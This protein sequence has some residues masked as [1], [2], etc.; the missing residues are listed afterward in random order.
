ME[1][2]PTELS[3]SYNEHLGAYLAVHSWETSGQLVGR[4]AP[5]PW[6]PGSEPTVL[7]TPRIP[8]RN[9]LVYNA[10]L[11][12]AGKEHAE[13]SKAQGKIIYVSYVEFEEYFP[14]LIELTFS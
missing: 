8:L 9:P 4:L 10:P 13:Y 7:W 5:N 2:M 14:R 11:V 3:V 1:G 6:G 12:Y